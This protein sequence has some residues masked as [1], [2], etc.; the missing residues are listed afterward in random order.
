MK[1]FIKVIFA[2]CLISITLFSSC[3]K[4]LEVGAPIN[5]VDSKVAFSTEVAALSSVSGLYNNPNFV[6]HTGYPEYPL[7]SAVSYLTGMAADEVYDVYPYYESFR[8]NTIPA[9][10]NLNNNMWNSAYKEIHF[11]NVAIEGLT[12]STGI[13]EAS[14]KQLLGECYTL[15]ALCFFYLTNMYGDVPLVLTSSVATNATMPR[16]AQTAVY[17]QMVADLT[18]A[19]SLLTD[20]YPTALRVRINKTAA[21]ALL[22]RVYLYQQNW[23]AAESQASSIINNTNYGLANIDNTFINT[24]SETIW[25]LF[26]PF[27]YNIYGRNYIPA[28][29]A[30]ENVIYVSLETSFEAGDQRKVKWMK[31]GTAS[32]IPAYYPFK[33]K[34][35]AS[36]TAGNEYLVMFRLSEQYLIRAEARAHQSK[37]TGIGSAAEDLLAV[38]ARAGLGNVTATD[39][40][41][42][43]LAIENERYHELFTEGHRWFDLKRTGRATAVLGPKKPGWKSTA[44]LYPIPAQQ[45][46]INK[47]LTQNLGYEN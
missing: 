43:L 45:R 11:I 16:T 28:G 15:R 37:L 1:I 13:S 3:K 34:L 18:T 24:S 40:P 7:V 17:A 19:Q 42:M 31:A 20:A 4:Y 2:S 33:Y 12:A 41:G 46:L 26:T 21:T 6:A 23:A 14:R 39:E 10:D 36:T 22:A 38:R 5:Q 47:T 8:T 35:P 30:I 27:G 9:A 44:V 25:Q 32:G 29:T